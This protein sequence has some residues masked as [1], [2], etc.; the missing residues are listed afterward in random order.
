MPKLK[1]FVAY[2]SKVEA[3]MRPYFARSVGE[4]MREW[5]RACND[6]QSMMCQHPEDFTL[7]ETGEYDEKT[8]RF[9]QLEALRPLG[10]ALEVKRTPTAV[11]PVPALKAMK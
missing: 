10:T 1:V 2:D 5:E 4:I 3:Y 6:P 11:E 9:T 7:F 8:G